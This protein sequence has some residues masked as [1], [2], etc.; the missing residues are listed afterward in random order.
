[1][2]SADLVAREALSNTSLISQVRKEFGDEVFEKDDII[3]RRKLGEIVF[4]DAVKLK[5]LN[6]ITHPY[7]VNRMLEMQKCAFDS[8]KDFVV[9]DAP[10][11]YET[12][13]DQYCNETWV[14]TA[15]YEQRIARV[16]QRDKLSYEQAKRRADSRVS[17]SE[18]IKRA[19]EV[20]ENTI[21]IDALER[22]V[23]E[24]FE[25]L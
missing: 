9:F 22:L 17:D 15:P 2:I 21:S 14:V 20:I 1:M 3:N 7:I 10:L 16:M 23:K 13:L 4:S 5:K 12:N 11:L 18:L 6:E 8:G 19:D 24:L 25:K